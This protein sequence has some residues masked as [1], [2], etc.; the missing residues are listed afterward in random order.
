[1]RF[2]PVSLEPLGG[3]DEIVPTW[4]HRCQPRSDVPRATL[5]RRLLV[6]SAMHALRLAATFLLLALACRQQGSQQPGNGGVPS[7]GRGPAVPLEVQE[8]RASFVSAEL[9]G[10]VSA[11][12]EKFHNQQLVAA[13][14]SLAFGTVVRVTNVKNGKA[15]T[16]RIID[17]G[18]SKA[19][20]EDGVVIDLSRAAA[21]RL[22][23]AT[24]EKGTAVV[25]VE[26]IAPQ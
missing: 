26:V 8:G 11:S 12:G 18:P 17:R 19:N 20:R 4:R 21:R 10:R 6:R 13:H 9:E 15:V 16:V 7:H 14:P 3:R 24:H 22:G 1:M 23:F 25:R 2:A 5:A